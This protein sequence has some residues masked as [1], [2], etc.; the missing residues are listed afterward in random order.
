ML[1]LSG[2]VCID[3][4]AAAVWARLAALDEIPLGPEHGLSHIHI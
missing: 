1:R 4:P 2:S 3:A